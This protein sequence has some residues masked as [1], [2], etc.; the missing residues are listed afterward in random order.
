MI[1]IAPYAQQLRNGLENPKNYPLG[2]WDEVLRLLGDREPIIQVG[3]DGENQLVPDF[4]KNLSTSQLYELLDACRTWVS[5]D[6][7]FQHLAWDY[8][9]FGHVIF[10]QSDPLIFGHP[11][12]NN[13]LRSRTFL[14]ANQFLM[15]EQAQYQLAAYV[16]P[17]EVYA[18]LRSAELHTLSDVP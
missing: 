5:V 9:K 13:L 8:G 10:S 6:S 16:A 11:E 18:A 4:R 2:Y 1:V 12:N 14:R 15:W 7:Y 3:V 17:G